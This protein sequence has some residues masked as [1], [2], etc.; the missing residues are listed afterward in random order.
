MLLPPHNDMRQKLLSLLVVVM[1]L[2]TMFS[3]LSGC[4]GNMQLVDTT[5][6][7]DKAYVAIPGQNP[8]DGRVD[9]W[10][11]FDDC[12]MVQVVIDG[13]TYYTH[14]SNVVLVRSK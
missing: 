13:A 4:G 12:D 2:V 3:C 7:F 10:K 8:V 11:D 6:A 1:I 5:Y 9:S 14:G